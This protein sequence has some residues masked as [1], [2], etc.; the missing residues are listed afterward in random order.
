MRLF[1]GENATFARPK[2]G[3]RGVF[4]SRDGIRPGFRGENGS[5]GALRR[6]GTGPE[7]GPE[8]PGELSPFRAV[9][10]MMPV[11]RTAFGRPREGVVKPKAKKSCARS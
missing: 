9:G 7:S 5:Y 4:L 1:A 3:L 11:S 6:A 8:S 10:E 2:A